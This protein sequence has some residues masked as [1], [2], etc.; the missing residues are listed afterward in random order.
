MCDNSGLAIP[1]FWFV[2]LIY[3]TELVVYSV[4]KSK[5]Q[6]LFQ[7]AIH[8][9]TTNTNYKYNTTD[10]LPLNNPFE[11]RKTMRDVGSLLLVLLM[12]ISIH[13]TVSSFLLTNIQKSLLP[14]RH[15]AN[16]N[17]LHQSIELEA[18]AS[19]VTDRITQRHLRF[20][21]VGR[22]YVTEQENTTVRNSL[23]APHLQILERLTQAT[24]AIVGLGGVGS[25]AAE[26]L[27]RSGI[28]NLILIDLDDICIS[29]TNRQ[30]HTMS[31][32]VGQMKIDEMRRRILDIN[33]DCQITTI[34]D[35]ITPENVHSI[36]NS[37]LPDLTV[38]LDAIDGQTAKTA[39]IAACVEK[40]IPIVTCG[41]SAGKVDPTKITCD[42]L[43]RANGDKLLTACRRN[44][45]KEYG[46]LVGKKMTQF[47]GIKPRKW[48]VQAVYSL[49]DQKDLPEGDDNV[50]GLRRCDGAL[51][52]ACFVPATCGFVAA[53]KIVDMIAN[54][55]LIF[56]KPQTKS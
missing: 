46:F 27:C 5:S 33:P 3:G 35:F 26:A 9:S 53:S 38:C 34:H 2:E 49:E 22:L 14:Q 10:S 20:Q 51:G 37:L 19:I 17:T 41:G 47:K 16:D 44:L 40:N 45:R 24:V 25:W 11:Y 48:G 52:T 43:T 28:G 32:T 12:A 56:P 23:L 30:I 31:S 1:A 4:S 15:T 36:L 6:P 39:L 13:T 42:D 29:N 50:S 8:C 7:F 18:D 55:R 54:D 21:G